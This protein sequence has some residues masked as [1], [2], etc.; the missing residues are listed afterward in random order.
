MMH[1]HP[2][3]PAYMRIA[4]LVSDVTSIALQAVGYQSMMPAL[5]PPLPRGGS[6]GSVPA[7]QR[8]Q[9]TR[10]FRRWLDRGER[11]PM[12]YQV[13]WPV[14][15]GERDRL[16]VD[17]G[18]HCALPSEGDVARQLAAD[19]LAVECIVNA[20][21]LPFEGSALLSVDSSESATTRA[22][23]ISGP[24]GSLMPFATS[25][26]EQPWAFHPRDEMCAPVH[27]TSLRIALTM[28]TDLLLDFYPELE[29]APR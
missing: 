4:L 15:S 5:V 6:V 28:L 1:A 29:A 11:L 20:L 12:R 10:L 8:L 9:I 3:S 2:L 23:Y 24:G 14:P 7:S 13:L 26:C 19:S 17:V 18:A 21:R 27:Q 25:T 22:F 16:S